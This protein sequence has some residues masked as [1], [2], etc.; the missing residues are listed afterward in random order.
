MKR[1]TRDMFLNW[2]GGDDIWT[3]HD[4]LITYVLSILDFETDIN[5][6]R[7]EIIDYNEEDNEKTRRVK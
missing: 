7:N 3:Q 2:Q 4:D 5:N 6:L 1:I